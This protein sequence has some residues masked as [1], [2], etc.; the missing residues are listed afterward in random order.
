[1]EQSRL[2]HQVPHLSVSSSPPPSLFLIVPL[3]SIHIKGKHKHCDILFDCG[4][5]DEQVLSARYVFITHGHIDHIGACISHARAKSL[6]SSPVTYYVPLSCFEGLLEAKTAFERLE[7]KEIPMKI[8]GIAPNEPPVEIARGYKVFAFPT[9]HRVA[10]QGYA[11][12]HCQPGGLLE[13]YIG[14][15]HQQLAN[16][17]QQHINIHAAVKE[18]VEVVYTGDTIFSALLAPALSFV[19]T[20]E[21]LLMEMTY[22]DGD[23]A[24]AAKYGHIHLDDFIEHAALFQNQ[25]VIFMH[26]SSR[27]GTGAW[28]LDVLRRRLPYD[29]SQRCAV[30]LKG[31]GFNQSVTR[32]IRSEESHSR[33]TSG[34][35]EFEREGVGRAGRGRGERRRG[36]EED[37]EEVLLSDRCLPCEAP[38][39]PPLD[40]ATGEA[41]GDRAVSEKKKKRRKS[42]PPTHSL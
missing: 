39:A 40:L 2:C 22:L 11:I 36:E 27:Y 35:R 28:V 10:S 41:T 30:A 18:T 8:V 16:L 3:H 21:I 14:A 34:G 13:P 24:K 25:Q 5:L 26:L 15:T 9:S 42:L 1:V 19:F 23:R 4:N 31:F 37:I 29:V 33:G 17:R 38:V 12:V 32:L 7:G 20:A 6:S